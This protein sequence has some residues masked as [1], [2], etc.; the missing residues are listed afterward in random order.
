MA[1][2]AGGRRRQRRCYQR[3]YDTLQARL[4]DHD[5]KQRCLPKHRRTPAQRVRICPSEPSAALGRDK[6]KVFRPLYN[7][8]IVQ[9]LDSPFVLGYGVYATNSDS[10]LLPGMLRRTQQLTGKMVQTALTD[11]IYATL[12]SVRYCRDNGVQLYAPAGPGSVSGKTEGKG[13]NEAAP[14]TDK[15]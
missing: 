13:P 6:F 10:G 1:A 9:D 5:K 12:T 2:T 11:G 4:R 3:A 8:Q 15:M 14:Q 7:V